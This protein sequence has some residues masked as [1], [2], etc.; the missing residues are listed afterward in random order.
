[1][2][3]QAREMGVEVFCLDKIILGIETPETYS[4]FI[5]DSTLH[6]LY[7]QTTARTLEYVIFFCN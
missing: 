2:V 7:M 1:M 6:P 3:K 4:L 5:M